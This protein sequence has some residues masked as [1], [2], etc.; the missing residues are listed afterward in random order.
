MMNLFTF[1]VHEESERC[2]FDRMCERQL[3][4]LRNEESKNSENENNHVKSVMIMKRVKGR[5]KVLKI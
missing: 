1:I 2:K 4:M 5:F 3:C